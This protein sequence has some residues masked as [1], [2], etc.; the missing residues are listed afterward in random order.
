MLAHAVAHALFAAIPPPPAHALSCNASG[1]FVIAVGT[2]DRFSFTSIL[3]PH[4]TG[5][6]VDT[7][8][9]DGGCM[10]NATATSYSMRR[11]I[12]PCGHGCYE[13]ADTYSTHVSVKGHIGVRFDTLVERSGPR[14]AHC[15]LR[16]WTA[17]NLSN[18]ADSC[19]HVGGK[20]NMWAAST[21]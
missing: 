19:I 21:T 8:H 18:R 1:K 4:V 12:R 3:L 11:S 10:M 5:M 20:Y 6:V 17:H 9:A 2:A 15:V 13:V 7:T 16:P 14:L